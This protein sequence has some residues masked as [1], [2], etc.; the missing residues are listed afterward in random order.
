MSE[1]QHESD[2]VRITQREIYDR[3]VSTGN[4]VD[5]LLEGLNP[6]KQRAD[7]HETRLKSLEVAHV[8]LSPLPAAYAELLR[9]VTELRIGAARSDWL[10]RLALG[11]L[12]AVLGGVVLWL[13]T[14][15]A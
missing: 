11:L 9:V 1:Q 13:I 10:P 3:V 6:L 7:D 8:A 5:Q 15:P 12:G 4:K 2:G 14:R